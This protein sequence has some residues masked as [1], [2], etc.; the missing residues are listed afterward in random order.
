[1]KIIFTKCLNALTIFLKRKL[2]LLLQKYIG[3]SSFWIMLDFYENCMYV[4]LTIFTKLNKWKS[5]SSTDFSDYFLLKNSSVSHMI[6]KTNRLAAICN[7]PKNR[8]ISS[9][10]YNLEGCDSA[11]LLDCQSRIHFV[12]REITI[13]CNFIFSNGTVVP[14]QKEIKQRYI[15]RSRWASCCS[16][17]SYPRFTKCV[18]ITS[19]YHTDTVWRCSILLK[20]MSLSW[21]KGTSSF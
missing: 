20:Y 14:S 4:G 2:S 8:L 16:I 12:L 18:I 3:V 10:L 5:L 13:K 7:F 9:L 1:M 21:A 19:A 11:V 6:F 15:W 17:P